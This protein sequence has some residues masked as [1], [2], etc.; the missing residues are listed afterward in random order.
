MGRGDW[1]IVNE[2]FK[3][4]LITGLSMNPLYVGEG[5][6]KDNSMKAKIVE[7]KDF[8]NHTENVAFENMHIGEIYVS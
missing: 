3:K 6:E 7:F 1:M 2:S 4:G 8:D 5:T